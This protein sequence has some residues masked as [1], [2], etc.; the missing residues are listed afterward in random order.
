MN[1]VDLCAVYLLMLLLL[2]VI[3]CVRSTRERRVE[4]KN[5][6]W[7]QRKNYVSLIASRGTTRAPH[8]QRER[9]NKNSEKCE[10]FGPC[11]QVRCRTPTINHIHNRHANKH[12]IC[13]RERTNKKNY[14]KT[15]AAQL[16][17]KPHDSDNVVFFSGNFYLLFLRRHTRWTGFTYQCHVELIV[18]LVKYENSRDHQQNTQ[19]QKK[20][21]KFVNGR[22][23]QWAAG[24]NIPFCG[25]R[26]TFFRFDFCIFELLLWKCEIFSIRF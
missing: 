26:S 11:D 2:L 17:L 6:F 3:V 24:G 7:I 5:F 23:M 10:L 12:S 21:E 22:H 8:H 13:S 19:K 25:F 15:E 9:E 14:F 4:K 20:F 1:V 16:P 18:S